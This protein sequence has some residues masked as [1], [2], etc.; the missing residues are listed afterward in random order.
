MEAELLLEQDEIKKT[1]IFSP[2]WQNDDNVL[3]FF[4][5]EKEGGT[6]KPWELYATARGSAGQQ[7][8]KEQ[9]WTLLWATYCAMPLKI[10][11]QKH[12]SKLGSQCLT[13]TF[14]GAKI[15]HLNNM[16]IIMSS[17]K[18]QKSI[19]AKID[20]FSILFE[21][22][23]EEAMFPWLAFLNTEVCGNTSVLCTFAWLLTVKV[24][25]RWDCAMLCLPPVSLFITFQ[26]WRSSKL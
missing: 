26:L 21:S 15:H 16:V 23:D 10:C 24:Y 22:Y 1:T 19:Y 17:R 13:D 14:I 25:H 6:T 12:S 5:K 7:M 9:I 4:R 20:N 8:E 2:I 18:S 3:C 11:F